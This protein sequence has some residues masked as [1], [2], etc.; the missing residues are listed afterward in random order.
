MDVGIPKTM[1][2]ELALIGMVQYYSYIWPIK[3]HMLAPLTE[4]DSGPKSGK[5]SWNDAFEESLKQLNHMLS[6]ENLLNYIDWT[7]N[8]TV[9]TDAFDKMFG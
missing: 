5:Y 3:S 9:H 1:T 4:V 7:I 8:S 6:A 2:E